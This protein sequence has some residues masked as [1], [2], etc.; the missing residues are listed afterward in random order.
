MTSSWSAG[1]AEM[2]EALALLQA[3]AVPTH[4]LITARYPLEQTGEALAAQR[5]GTVLK[6]VVIP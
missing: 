5:A 1:P 4:E 6:A 2:R 3:G